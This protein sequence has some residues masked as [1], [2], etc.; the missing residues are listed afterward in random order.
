MEY[1]GGPEKDQNVGVFGGGGLCSLSSDS[2]GQ[3][4]ILW[5]DGDSPGMDG[6]QVGVFKETH[7][8]GLCCFFKTHYGCQL[9]LQ[10]CLEVLGDLS[11]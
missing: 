4:D 1:W 3:L 7:E 9:K 2:S 5:H 10:I 8:I 6:T 11:H